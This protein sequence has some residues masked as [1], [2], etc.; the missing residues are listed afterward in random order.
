MS[1]VSEPI[2]SDAPEAAPEPQPPPNTVSEP[3][4]VELPADLRDL[5][6]VFDKQS[7]GTLSKADALHLLRLGKHRFSEAELRDITQP[8]P[9][10]VTKAQFA[11]VHS[12]LP[13]VDPN[14]QRQ[15]LA[16]ALEFLSGYS[17][18]LKLSQ[19]SELLAELGEE[20]PNDE[21]QQAL[22]EF[23]HASDAVKVTALLDYLCNPLE[24]PLPKIRA[25]QVQLAASKK[26]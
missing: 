10:L 3:A 19:L 21:V 8:L 20:I 11:Q 24:S 16:Q 2:S 13:P 26:H 12:K 17:G 5:W 6:L 4:E 22:G 1:E 7:T 14:S 15:E 25:L 9:E 23:A 18:T